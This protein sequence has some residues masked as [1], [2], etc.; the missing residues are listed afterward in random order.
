MA[1]TLLFWSAKYIFYVFSFQK[2]KENIGTRPHIS[3]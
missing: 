1:T 3:I 2:F